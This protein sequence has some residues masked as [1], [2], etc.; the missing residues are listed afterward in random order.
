MAEPS[1]FYI[2][3]VHKAGVHSSTAGVLF[4]EIFLFE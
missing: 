1:V 3:D 4:K 2:A